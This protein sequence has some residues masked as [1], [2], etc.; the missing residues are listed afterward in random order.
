MSLGLL[1]FIAYLVDKMQDWVLIGR[2][3]A[4]GIHKLF[5]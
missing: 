3:L 5:H 1:A 2:W 4:A